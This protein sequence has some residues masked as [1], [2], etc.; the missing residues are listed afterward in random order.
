MKRVK[1]KKDPRGYCYVLN[2]TDFAIRYAYLNGRKP[3]YIAGTMGMNTPAVMA[4]IKRIQKYF[5]P[6]DKVDIS[7]LRSQFFD[8]VPLVYAS[9]RHNLIKKNPGV[10]VSTAQGMQI[11]Q[12]K[13]QEEIGFAN[14]TN[15]ELVALVRSALGVDTANDASEQADTGGVT[16]GDT[17]AERIRDTKN[18]D[19]D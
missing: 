10:T 3:D 11:F 9:L 5:T 2:D 8:L 4:R 12:T 13:S 1:T 6:Q 16:A 15:E 14:L 7:Q 18:L 19:S 17:T